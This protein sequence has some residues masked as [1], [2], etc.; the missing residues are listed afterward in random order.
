VKLEAARDAMVEL[1]RFTA[2]Q[3]AARLGASRP[4]AQRSIEWALSRG[5]VI[6]VGV[7]RTGKRGRPA[8]LFAHAPLPAGPSERPRSPLEA[9]TMKRPA[10]SS[11]HHR[12]RRR[13]GS[14]EIEQLFRQLER[15]GWRV[16]WGSGHPKLLAP[17]GEPV[18]MAASPSDHRAMKNLRAR[19]RRAGAE[20]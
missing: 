11:P 10:S 1:G 8:R 17:S 20:L 15:Q 3:L 14:Q 7:E 2:P 9:L 19:L 12:G 13:G 18:V 16:R 6:E 5:I 4:T